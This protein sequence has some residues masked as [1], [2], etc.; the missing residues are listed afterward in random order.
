LLIKT[1]GL[2]GVLQQALK[3]MAGKIEVAFIVGSFATASELAG[4]DIDIMLVGDFGLADIASS[5]KMAEQRV[6][7]VINPV[8]FTPTEVRQK[9][10]N[11]NHFLENIRKSNKIILF[12]KDN[13][14][15]DALSSK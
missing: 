13:D 1:V 9:L 12:G 4:S 8:V 3:P 2:V 6:Q 10:S 14:L 5:I 11:K 7:R 15:V